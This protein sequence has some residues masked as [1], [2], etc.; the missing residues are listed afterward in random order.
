M[1]AP[2]P[3]V[4]LDK[5][6]QTTG[7]D[8]TTYT[9]SLPM[10][11]SKILEYVNNGYDALFVTLIDKIDRKILETGKENGL[12]VVSSM[13]VGFNHIDTDVA[14]EL[15]IKVGNTPGV[16]TESV[17]DTVMLLI[18]SGCRRAYEAIEAVRNGEWGVWK[19]EW[20]CGIDLN[21]ATVGIIGLGRIGLAVAKRLKAFDCR[22]MYSDIQ[23]NKEAEK[24][25]AEYTDLNNILEKADIVVPLC[26]LTDE[27][28][29][30]F[31][32][33]LFGKMKKNSVFVNCSRGEV[34]QQDDLYEA[35]KNN[36][37]FGAA[38]DVTVPEPL[39]TNHKL[40]DLKNCYILPHI[41]SATKSTRN[42]MAELAADNLINAFK[43][44]DMKTPVV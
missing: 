44:K 5:L 7:L 39:P 6:N 9:G 42:A 18:L 1:T 35:L 2:V 17:A 8:L 37:I 12:K 23:V 34:V 32:K 33:K 30:M 26:P 14:K 22:I 40:L 16:L 41:A 13:S 38:L 29:G 31:N 21:H 15:G 24:L 25:E 28:K 43:G 3:K 11:H 36:T 20:M 4:G 27:T 10:P 19:A